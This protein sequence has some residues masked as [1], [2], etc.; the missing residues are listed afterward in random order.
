MKPAV[1]GFL[2]LIKPP[3]MTSFDMVRWVRRRTAQRR[4]GHAGTLDPAASGVLP[5]CL[6]QATRLVEFVIEARKSYCADIRFGTAT[7]TYDATGEVTRTGDASQ[8]D[9]GRI[10]EL[11]RSFT[12][13]FEQYP[14][15]FSAIRVGGTRLY[16]YARRGE[17]VERQPRRVEVY[18]MRLLDWQ[19]PLLSLQID[20]S[21][22]TYI[23]S[24][25]HDLGEAAGCA[26]HL[27]HLVRLAAGPF[28]FGDATCLT[29]LEDAIEGGYWERLLHPMDCV[30]ES[31][32]ALVVN[33]HQERWLVNGQP[34]PVTP[35]VQDRLF[36][37]GMAPGNCRAYSEQGELVALL[38]HTRG[39]WQPF[40]VFHPR[41]VSMPS[42]E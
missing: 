7:N 9:L 18:R 16:E 42:S 3:G 11:L 21:R 12:G 25:A 40:K 2:N 29:A 6:G 38:K 19:P 17:E 5:L 22:G 20:C 32:P 8:L 26:A 37:L 15:M 33:S 35:R 30:V 13:S 10:R 36:R 1:D 41:Y 28:Q 14:P 34:L 39:L 27:A 24:L 4:V 31:W 23:R